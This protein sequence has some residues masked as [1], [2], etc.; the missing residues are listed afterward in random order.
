MRL[1]GDAAWA[2][3]LFPRTRERGDFFSTEIAFRGHRA[4]HSSRCL[5]WDQTPLMLLQNVSSTKEAAGSGVRQI[6]SMGLWRHIT[7][8]IFGTPLVCDP[9]TCFLQE[10][11]VRN[12]LACLLARNPPKWVSRI[13]FPH[14]SPIPMARYL[15]LSPVAGSR[16]TAPRR[17]LPWG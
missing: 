7:L 1:E 12:L 9:D 5:F 3:G 8:K 16:S 11:T 13:S 17:T 2:H 14:G 15:M 4:P 10:R 6:P